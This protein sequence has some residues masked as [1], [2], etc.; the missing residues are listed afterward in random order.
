MDWNCRT[1]YPPHIFFSNR[2]IANQGTRIFFPDDQQYLLIQQSFY[3]NI[4]TDA[5]Y[6][7]NF[8][9]GATLAAV[10]DKTTQAWDYQANALNNIGELTSAETDNGV[11]GA[12]DL[13]VWT[14]TNFQKSTL[15]AAT[16]TYT[17]TAPSGP[18]N[19]TLKLV[20]D[21]TGGR[22]IVWPGTVV[23]GDSGEPSWTLMAASETAIMNMYY[24]GTSYFV[25]GVETGL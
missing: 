16:V 11:S 8:T 6:D 10:I 19:I 14:T 23:W 17:F 4:Q 25:M 9:V 20:Q 15:T 18:T 2:C 5:G 3:L 7:L 1:T 21:A 12:A 13:I 22:D 24:D